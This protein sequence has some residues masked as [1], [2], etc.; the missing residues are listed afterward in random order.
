VRIIKPVLAHLLTRVLRHELLAISCEVPEEGVEQREEEL[1]GFSLE[2]LQKPDP[3]GAQV[4]DLVQ[5]FSSILNRADLCKVDVL[6]A[7]RS[8]QGDQTLAS[9]TLDAQKR[10]LE[11]YIPVNDANAPDVTASLKLATAELL[12][13]IKLSAPAFVYRNSEEMDQG[14]DDQMGESVDSKIT[15]RLP[16]QYLKPE[17]KK[18]TLND[19]GLSTIKSL[20][21]QW[22]VGTDVSDY[23]WP[24]LSNWRE[25]SPDLDADKPSLASIPRSQPASARTRASSL[26]PITPPPIQS[27]SRPQDS[28]GPSRP[29]RKHQSQVHFAEDTQSQTQDFASTQLVPGPHGNRKPVSFRRPLAKKRRTGF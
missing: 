26:R 3:D 13:D 2:L 19:P 5:Q 1:K 4:D 21:G 25:P 27:P 29:R 6:D 15:Q 24:G 10:L 17:F 18:K 8:I 7:A 14:E 12:C 28:A 22:K 9:N 23:K 16:T 11:R 20:V